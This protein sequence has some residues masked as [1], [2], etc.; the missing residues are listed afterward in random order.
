M[1]AREETMRDLMRRSQACDKQAYAV[2]L[3]QTARWLA[4]FFARKIWADSIN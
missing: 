3:E 4:R 2:L 1:I